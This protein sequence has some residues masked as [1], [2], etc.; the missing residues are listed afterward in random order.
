MIENLAFKNKIS[1][2]LTLNSDSTGSLLEE[3]EKCAPTFET[4]QK[5]NND[6]AALLYSS[7][8]TGTP[9]G[10]YADTSESLK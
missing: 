8:T 2:V 9:K 5:E 1:K 6:L 10:N 4:V 7:G 3:A